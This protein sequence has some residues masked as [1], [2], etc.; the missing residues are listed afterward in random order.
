MLLQFLLLLLLV[1]DAG[2]AM[3]APASSLEWLQGQNVA[4]W[5]DSA[6]VASVAPLQSLGIVD[7]TTNPSLVYQ[8]ACTPGGAANEA[9]RRVAAT[10]KSYG[11][12]PAPHELQNLAGQ[13]AVEVG[14]QL[15][16]Q[17]PGRVCTQ[18][19]MRLCNDCEA[20]VSEARHIMERYEQ[21]T[22]GSRERIL[23]KVPATWAGYQ[24]VERLQAE[25]IQCLV[26]LVCSTEQAMAAASAGAAILATYVGRVGDW[27]KKALGLSEDFIWPAASDPG[28]L[29]TTEIVRLLKEGGFQTEVMGASFRNV[30]QLEYLAS[31]GCHHLT[32]APSLILQAAKQPVGMDIANSNSPMQKSLH[33]EATSTTS[34]GR[35]SQEEY[36]ERIRRDKA[37]FQVSC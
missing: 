23:I 7:A 10:V 33:P 36:E 37:G 26:T 34:S 15:L 14:S 30:A 16:M 3:I 11:R 20:M 27:H 2:V 6:D 8:A 28:V 13:V 17:I 21:C 9:M 19:D 4:I 12:S 22:N 25:G 35:R 29:M 24:A 32:V 31:R 5:A 1:V 18:V